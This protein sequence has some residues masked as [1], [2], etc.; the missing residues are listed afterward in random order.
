MSVQ[1]FVNTSVLG[2]T[3]ADSTKA[4][5]EDA[6][7]DCEGAQLDLADINLNRYWNFYQS[8]CA[9]ALHGGGK[10][11]AT[12]THHDVIECVRMLRSG[13]ERRAVKDH[14]RA[15]LTAFH[16]NEDEILD[17]SIDLAASVLLM[18][19]FC[20]YPYGFS[21]RR[22]LNWNNGA[23]LQT[24]LHDFFGADAA[25][26]ETRTD[27]VVKLEKI[28]TA[29]NL[30]RIAGLQVVWT[31]NM[32]DHLRLTD[33]DRRVHVFHH[34]SFLE[35]QK[36]SPNCLLPCGLADETLRTLA[37][38][39]PSSDPATRTWFTRQA[40]YPDLDK[41]ASRYRRLKTDDRQIEK[42]P[43]WRDRLL[44]LKQVFDEAQPQSLS[45]W[46]YDRRNGVQWY[47][48]WVAV[49]V[50]ILT[51]VFGLIQ[52]IEGGLQV[53]ASFKALEASAPQ[54]R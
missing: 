18:M 45:Q 41:R 49:L 33:D 20:T 34:A 27:S 25:A 15:R 8:E 10:H 4:A 1:T 52:S 21:G 28:F 51:I 6:F 30:M 3:I 48:F 35:V 11:I 12:R 14:L 46:W 38:L 5:L 32:L 44:M 53:Y 54:S 24:L 19:N 40:N 13:Q 2:A 16:T 37:L 39:I 36:H 43:F 42:F 50:L 26:A 23:S 7:W 29:H 9:K 17:N 31:D 47:T 22:W